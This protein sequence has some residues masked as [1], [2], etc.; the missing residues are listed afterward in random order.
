MSGLREPSALSRSS[1]VAAA[2]VIAFFGIG[3]L[4]STM[5]THAPRDVASTLRHGEPPALAVVGRAEAGGS[6]PAAK[7]ASPAGKVNV[8]TASAAELELLP[9]IGPALASRI[10]AHR[11]EHGPFKALGDLDRVKGI[12]PKLLER[13]KPL[14]V[15]E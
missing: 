4:V 5:R 13:V 8:N 10:I 6:K 7:V 1:R 3:I 12:G 9:G 15:F 2:A 11:T 14:V